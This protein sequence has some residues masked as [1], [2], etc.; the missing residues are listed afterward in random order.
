MSP[1]P[2]DNRPRG[3]ADRLLVAWHGLAVGAILCVGPLAM[4]VVGVLTLFRARRFQAE[5]LGRAI[6]R[7][8]LVVS[9]IR[10]EVRGPVAIDRPAVYVSNHTSMLDLPVF[11]ALALP[12][13]RAFLSEFLRK[14]PP[15]AVIGRAIGLFW[16]APHAETERRRARFMAAEEVL[17]RTGD[18]VYM[19]PEGRRV[20]DG[21]IAPFNRAFVH[22]ATN[23][24]RPIV[25]FV[26]DIPPESDPQS[27]YAFRPG[28]VVVHPLGPIETD[29]WTV[30]DIDRNV[31]A[32]R[33]RFLDFE[34]SR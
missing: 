20:R 25:P 12:R 33:E 13:T 5:V 11:L 14:A 6:G 34:R 29:G 18:S 10:L 30:D 7:A 24:G 3:P 2:V 19:T 17:R 22:L 1:A 9:R 26:I 32:V 15:I 21:R 28:T 8:C 27:G 4:L 23:L 31:A 16:T